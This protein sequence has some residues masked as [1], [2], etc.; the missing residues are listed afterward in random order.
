[1]I[2]FLPAALLSSFEDNFPSLHAWDAQPCSR[3]APGELGNQMLDRGWHPSAS[4]QVHG[5]HRPRVCHCGSA[6]DWKSSSLPCTW[7]WRQSTRKWNLTFKMSWFQRKKTNRKYPPRCW[8]ALLQLDHVSSARR[9]HWFLEH[10]ACMA[11]CQILLSSLTFSCQ[12]LWAVET[13]WSF[14]VISDSLRP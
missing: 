10:R 14:F 12:P 5:S 13:W 1:M 11:S 9:R 3:Q 4:L 2:L 8:A 6:A 7:T